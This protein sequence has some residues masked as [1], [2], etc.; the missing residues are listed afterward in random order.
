MLKLPAIVAGL[1]FIAAGIITKGIVIGCVGL[2]LF[3]AGIFIFPLDFGHY[4][5]D[6]EDQDKE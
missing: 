5:R 6:A 1:A 3:L 2:L 4:P